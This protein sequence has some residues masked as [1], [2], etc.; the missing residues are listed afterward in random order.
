MV[1]PLWYRIVA[2]LNN[3]IRL[4]DL[5]DGVV[6]ILDVP[7]SAVGFLALAEGARLGKEYAE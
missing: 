3:P 6:C 1:S 7:P 5:T 4:I 2:Q